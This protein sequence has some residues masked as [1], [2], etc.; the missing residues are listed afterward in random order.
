VVVGHSNAKQ[1]KEAKEKN[2]T[3]HAIKLQHKTG[4]KS[5]SPP[6]DKK[7]ATKMYRRGLVG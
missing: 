1:A 2:K 4:G 7:I 6:K 3:A 5:C